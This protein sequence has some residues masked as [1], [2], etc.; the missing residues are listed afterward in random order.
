MQVWD[1]IDP[2]LFGMGLV[3]KSKPDFPGNFHAKRRA[4]GANSVIATRFLSVRCEQSSPASASP[5]LRVID[6]LAS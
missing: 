2:T 6:R 3:T 5:L 1:Q 4:T